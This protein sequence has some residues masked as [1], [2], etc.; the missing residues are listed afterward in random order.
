MRDA[1]R[2]GLSDSYESAFRRFM[3]L[4]LAEPSV[5]RAGEVASLWRL[6]CWHEGEEIGLMN[7]PFE[8]RTLMNMLTKM[9]G[10]S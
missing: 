3:A 1:E 4:A 5:Q 10:V 8:A 9:T 2:D 7:D 6:R